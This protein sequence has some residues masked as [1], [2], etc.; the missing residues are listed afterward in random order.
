MPMHRD[1]YQKAGVEYV[2]YIAFVSLDDNIEWH[3]V[4]YKYTW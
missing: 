2:Y 4:F 3:G 1:G